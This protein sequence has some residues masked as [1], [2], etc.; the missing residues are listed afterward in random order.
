M[1]LSPRRLANALVLAGWCALFWFLLISGRVSLYLSSRTD[2][3]VPIGAVVLTFAT[4]GMLFSARSGGS[5]PLTR[6]DGVGSA[7]LLLP[8]VLVLALPPASL[9]SF[10]ATRRSS[11][12]TAGVAP[13]AAELASG[14]IS[15]ADVGGAL[16]SPDAMR[17]LRSRAGTEVGFI[18]FVTRESSASADEFTLNRFMISCCV[19]DA[20]AVRVRVIGTPAGLVKKDDWVSV[21]GKLYPLGD[22]VVVDASQ[23]EKVPQPKRPY[24]NP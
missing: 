24:L 7:L 10:A 20:L 12:A 17:A 5:E 2:W 19:A 18:G 15:L 22:D 1:K 21:T 11:L 8:V 13:S 23:V 14:D 9:S 4:I 16:R 6:S 3:I